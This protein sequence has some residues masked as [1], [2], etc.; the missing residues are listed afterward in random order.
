MAVVVDQ[1]QRPELF[2]D[3]FPEACPEESR[4]ERCPSP[5][6]SVMIVPAVTVDG[7]L[8]RKMHAVAKYLRYPVGKVKM[9]GNDEAR[10]TKEWRNPSD[11]E[12]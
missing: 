10:M 5:L 4:W 8:V 7:R 2:H 3:D 6:P 1:Q 11:E 9:R 12:A